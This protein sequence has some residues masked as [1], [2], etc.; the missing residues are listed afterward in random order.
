MKI[1]ETYFRQFDNEI[2]YDGT[3]IH[4]GNSIEARIMRGLGF[5]YMI[6]VL[7]PIAYLLILLYSMIF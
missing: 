3:V 7:L 1:N 4:G 2:G 6:L 5:L